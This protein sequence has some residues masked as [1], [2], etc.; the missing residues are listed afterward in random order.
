MSVVAA[1]DLAIKYI[2]DRRLPDKAIDLIDEASASVKMSVTSMPEDIAQIDKKI[3]QLEIEKQALLMEK[4]E[5][6]STRIKQIQKELAESNEEFNKLKSQWEEERKII[7]ES[8]DIKEQIQKFQH[9]AEL[10][11]KQTDYNKV[12]ELRY[13]K[14]PELEKKLQDWEIK[15]EELKNS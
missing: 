3:R 13:G 5:K 9:E 1:V 7:F 2:P 8:K 12:A 14:I 4:N 15:A 10:A 6:N 11:E